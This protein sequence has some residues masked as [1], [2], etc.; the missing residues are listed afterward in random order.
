MA[1]RLAQ[2]ALVPDA[3]I[4]EHIQE[5]RDFQLLL[6]DASEAGLEYMAEWM[7]GMFTAHSLYHGGPDPVRFEVDARILAKEPFDS[8]AKKCHLSVPAIT[9]Y[10]ALFFNVL[11]RLEATSYIAHTVIGPKLHEG[12]TPSDIDVLWK[13][14]GYHGGSL[15][16]DRL[17]YG[18]G[19]GHED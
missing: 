7:P 11:D 9:A 17:N 4:D 8:I 14:Y 6:A 13:F 2:G 5:A 12:L 19:P 10:E 18:A 15:V 16:L 1:A 3:W